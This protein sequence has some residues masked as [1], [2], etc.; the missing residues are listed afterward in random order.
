MGELALG[1]RGAGSRECFAGRGNYLLPDGITRIRLCDFSKNRAFLE[2][3][4]ENEHFFSKSHYKRHIST[5]IMATL[6]KI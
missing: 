4:G 6:E 1:K 3:T 2:T 5:V